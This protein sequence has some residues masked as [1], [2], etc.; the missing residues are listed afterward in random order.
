MQLVA[1]P[2]LKALVRHVRDLHSMY[3]YDQ[4]REQLWTP[5]REQLILERRGGFVFAK[6]EYL[7]GSLDSRRFGLA[8]QNDERQVCY[9]R[10]RLEEGW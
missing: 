5:V 10:S 2:E 4:L 6:R 8:R 1:R 9:Q 3:R 7:L